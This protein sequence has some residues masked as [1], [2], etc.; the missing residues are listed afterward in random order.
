MNGMNDNSSNY[1]LVMVNDDEKENRSPTQKKELGE[2][3]VRVFQ[4]TK[5]F[6]LVGRDEVGVGFGFHA[7]LCI[8]FH[9][10]SSNVYY[11]FIFVR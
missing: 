3:V 1:E 2:T 9:F 8:H 4:L 10:R 11:L 5:S 7:M 6:K